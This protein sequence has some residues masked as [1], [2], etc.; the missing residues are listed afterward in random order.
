MRHFA[1]F[2]RPVF[3]HQPQGYYAG[4]HFPAEYRNY[5]LA[6][7]LTHLLVRAPARR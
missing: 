7:M 5:T 1:R 2:P 4:L 6:V 3:H